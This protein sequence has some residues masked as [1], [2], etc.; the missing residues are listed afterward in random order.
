[1]ADMWEIY[2]LHVPVQRDHQ[3]VIHIHQNYGEELL[4]C[5]CFV[6]E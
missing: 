5:E 4:G 3:Q 6:Y 1:M 2:L